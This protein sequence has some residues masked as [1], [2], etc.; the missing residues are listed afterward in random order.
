M[1]QAENDKFE[2]EGKNLESDLAK[3]RKEL[4]KEKDKRDKKRE[5]CAKMK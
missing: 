1:I 3:H 4:A 5:E 2:T